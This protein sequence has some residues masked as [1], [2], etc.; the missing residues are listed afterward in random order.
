MQYP[1]SGPQSPR[2]P[3][4]GTGHVVLS[5]DAFMH[6]DSGGVGDDSSSHHKLL[7]RGA[8]RGLPTDASTGDLRKQGRRS[9]WLVLHCD[10]RMEEVFSD[11]RLVLKNL[12][13][14]SVAPR[15][16]RHLEPPPASAGGAEMA[17]EQLLV[18]CA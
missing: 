14:A 12:A 18:R 1:G 3:L 17:V 7:H 2:Q 5:T 9:R 8:G 6:S 16:L 11:K 13:L 4:L 10:G 15:D